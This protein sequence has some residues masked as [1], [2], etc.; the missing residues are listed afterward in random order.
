MS[1]WP[2]FLKNFSII[3][4]ADDDSCLKQGGFDGLDSEPDNLPGES[5][6]SGNF[7]DG[8]F[9]TQESADFL[10]LG[11][12]AGDHFADE[13]NLILPLFFPVVTPSGIRTCI[14]IFP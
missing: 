11:G 4:P 1:N 6:S 7:R 13:K 9:G 10:R 2:F 14:P 5:R 12:K 3:F 8:A